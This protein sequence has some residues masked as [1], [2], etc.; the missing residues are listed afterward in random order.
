MR[1]HIDYTFLMIPHKL[2]G[3]GNWEV[4]CYLGEL[5]YLPQHDGGTELRLGCNIDSLRLN[6]G[7]LHEC[8]TSHGDLST[9]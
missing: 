4:P 7:W 2:L 6:R 1:N 5:G 3:L 9:R 8:S